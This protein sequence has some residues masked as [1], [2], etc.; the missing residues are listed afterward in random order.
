MRRQ[1]RVF[2]WRGAKAR[3]HSKVDPAILIALR[4]EVQR[5]LAEEAEASE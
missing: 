1:M 5:R 3:R 4:E 2:G